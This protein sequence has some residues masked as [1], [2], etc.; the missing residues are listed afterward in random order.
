[1]VCCRH[2]V[3]NMP[4]MSSNTAGECS[5]TCQNQ[6]S[7]VCCYQRGRVHG[8]A[9][10]P[11][12]RAACAVRCSCRGVARPANGRQP[13]A[14]DKPM[15]LHSAQH[16]GFKKPSR[17]SEIRPQGR[18]ISGYTLSILR[19]SAVQMRW[20]EVIAIRL[21]SAHTHRVYMSPLFWRSSL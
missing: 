14:P 10:R 4:K 3:I 17:V 1:M 15:T 11:D 6:L 21:H 19:Q 13:G 16:L 7:T 18:A 5:G 8:A 9:V 20:Y 12:A 2:L